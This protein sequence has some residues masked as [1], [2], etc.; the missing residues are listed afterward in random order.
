MLSVC[1]FINGWQRWWYE[2]VAASRELT[3]LFIGS[4]VP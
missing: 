3:A 1:S 4:I 2:V